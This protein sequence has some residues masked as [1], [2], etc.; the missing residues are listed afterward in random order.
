MK[1]LFLTMFLLAMLTAGAQ[2]QV[3]INARVTGLKEGDKIFLLSNHGDWLDST[4]VKD[5]RFQFRLSIPEGRSYAI[6]LTR[7]YL[8]GQMREFYLEEGTLDLDIKNGTFYHCR[9]SG[10]SFAKDQQDYY[11]AI[12]QLNI[13][14]KMKANNEKFLE[15]QKNND[16]TTQNA[17]SKE[18]DRIL[19]LRRSTAQQW[20][21]QHSSSPVSSFALYSYGMPNNMQQMEELLNKLSPAARNNAP[22]KYYQQ[23]VAA[24]RAT[25]IGQIAPGFVQ[26]DT[27]GKPVALQDFR[28]KYVLIEFWASWCGPCREEN[29]ALIAAWQKYK[30]KNF[31]VLSVSLDSKKELWL[32]AIQKD[33]LNY[34]THVSDLKS[35]ENAIARQYGIG[36]V[37]A[38]L[39]LDPEGRIIAKN[40][41]GEGLEKQLAATLH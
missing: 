1:Y 2:K 20:A 11:S 29:P 35:W 15:A 37:P 19:A 6:Q 3:T 7:A 14:Q 17:L 9:I 27:A 31:T 40:L 21:V 8:D 4:L 38:N 23:K 30:D 33:Q 39:L 13:S 28:G 12:E 10:G 41:R 5:G 32:Q 24:A 16:T 22:G 18:A 25:A 36:S 26:N 34:W